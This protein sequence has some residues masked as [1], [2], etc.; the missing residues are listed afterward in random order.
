MKN[1]TYDPEKGFST[2]FD[3]TDNTLPGESGGLVIRSDD[4][5]EGEDEG[6]DE[7]KDKDIRQIRSIVFKS[8]SDSNVKI[9]TSYADGC[10]TVT[11][12]VYYV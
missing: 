1:S 2:S 6:G 7:D 5:D 4:E 8:A 3:F 12:G 11:I 9:T 10:M